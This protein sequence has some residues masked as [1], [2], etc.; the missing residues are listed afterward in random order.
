MASPRDLSLVEK[1]K[2]PV[3]IILC[4]ARGGVNPDY[5]FIARQTGGSVHTLTDDIT[6]LDKLVDGDV[7][8]VGFQNFLLHNEHFIPLENFSPLLR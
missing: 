5:L 6:G 8:K 3:H 7:V 4:G 1:V 2:R